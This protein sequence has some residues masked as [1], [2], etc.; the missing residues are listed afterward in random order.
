M[1]VDIWTIKEWWS[2]ARGA[3]VVAASWAGSD[4]EVSGDT[5]D[6]IALYSSILQWIINDTGKP[7]RLPPRGPATPI[8]APTLLLVTQAHQL[9]VCY[10]RTYVPSLKI[11][12][13]SLI[14][15]GVTSEN[16]P[17]PI[18]GE[19]GRIKLC[20]H[21]AIGKG[22]NGDYLPENILSASH[23]IYRIF[24]TNCNALPSSPIPNYKIVSV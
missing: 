9:Q 4:R 16:K 8:S 22:Y 21:A 20:R 15:P 17:H 24:N 10:I 13:C 3:G 11:M 23:D 19:S 5:L 7:S 1:Q 12:I 2:F 18:Y 6:S 14:Q